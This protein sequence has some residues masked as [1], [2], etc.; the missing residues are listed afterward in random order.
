MR[1]NWLVNVQYGWH[2]A[3]WRYPLFLYSRNSVPSCLFF[4][5]F[6]SSDI[7]SFL[8]VWVVQY[9]HYVCAF[10]F[11][12]QKRHWS[13]SIWQAF[14][15]YLRLSFLGVFLHQQWDIIANDYFFVSP[16]SSC[17]KG[18]KSIFSL[19]FLIPSFG[20]LILMNSWYVWVHVHTHIEDIFGSRNENV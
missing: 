20:F 19:Q 5:L 4:Y 9:S 6:L 7:S 17:W 8:I 18:P 2:G 10:S 14:H 15:L 3:C 16:F 11:C 13:S 1:H 12:R